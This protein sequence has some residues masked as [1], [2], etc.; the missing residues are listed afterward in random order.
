M[1][2]DDK[3]TNTV[4]TFP[5]SSEWIIDKL[6]PTR[7]VHLI[8]GSSGS[9]KTTLLF[10]ILQ[11]WTAGNPVFGFQSYPVPFVYISCDRSLASV[12]RT[13]SRIG[14]TFPRYSVVDSG[15]VGRSFTGDSGLLQSFRIPRTTK[16]IILDGMTSLCPDGKI[17]DHKVVA[18]F[19]ANL[20]TLCQAR[21]MTIIG[22]VHATKTKE[23]EK[24]LKPRERIV[25]STAWAA[26]SETIVILDPADA[27][28]DSSR[29]ILDIMPRNSAHIHKTLEFSPS[30]RL[31]E[32]E[33]ENTQSGKFLLEQ[34][35]D[36][37]STGQE[38]PTSAL[39][40]ARDNGISLRTME[41]WIAELVTEGKLEKVRKGVYR[42]MYIS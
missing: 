33:D 38:I 31:V 39:L 34:Y 6:F 20:A 24:I 18:N 11:D 21:D 13:M 14:F 41:R 19:L 17:N 26:Y 40:D 15:L 8:G 16:L 3:S 25:G 12:S 23:N 36:N 4:P 10:Q 37:Y 1:T 2:P 42:K 9:G 7:E 32:V 29:R 28:N 5:S 30:G 35:L 27:T 22:T